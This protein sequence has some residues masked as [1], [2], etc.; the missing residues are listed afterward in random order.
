MPDQPN[1]E[2]SADPQVKSLSAAP[3]VISAEHRAIYC[4]QVQLATS[5]YDVQFVL[6]RASALGGNPVNEILTTVFMSLH[7][8]KALSV[9]LSK[10]VKDCES[11]VGELT[12][13][14]RV[15]ESIAVAQASEPAAKP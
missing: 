12:V 1:S 14:A 2:A 8:A 6:M 5:E 4:N 15:L 11:R 7:Q 9:V 13:P 3:F 10:V